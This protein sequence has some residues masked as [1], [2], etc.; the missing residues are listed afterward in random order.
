M[1]MHIPLPRHPRPLVAGLLC[2]AMQAGPVVNAANVLHV[3]APVIRVE[4]IVFYRDDDGSPCSGETRRER[5]PAPRAGDLRRLQ[6]AV[7]IR[8]AI[9]EEIRFLQRPPDCRR[10]VAHYRVRYRLNGVIHETQ[11]P[12]HPGDSIRVRVDLRPD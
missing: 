11:L 10:A 3:H 1:T 8:S 5:Q 2:I 12:R 7:S 4:P 6:P 9:E